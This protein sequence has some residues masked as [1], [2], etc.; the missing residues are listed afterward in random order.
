MKSGG[1]NLSGPSLVC[2]II[3]FSFVKLTLLNMTEAWTAHGVFPKIITREGRG[4]CRETE[5][6]KVCVKNGI[7]MIQYQ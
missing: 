4:E 2:S 1:G 6:K 5:F 7:A 3:D